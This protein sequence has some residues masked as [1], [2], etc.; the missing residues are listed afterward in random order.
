[1]VFDELFVYVFYRCLWYSFWIICSSRLLV[2][3]EWRQGLFSTDPRDARCF[4][5]SA[6]QT[7]LRW[8]DNILAIVVCTCRC[9]VGHGVFSWSS[10]RAQSWSLV[11]N[12][13]LVLVL[14]R[15][16][17]SLVQL[18]VLSLHFILGL[19]WVWYTSDGALCLLLR[20][21]RLLGQ[22]V[23]H[24]LMLTATVDT[25]LSFATATDIGRLPNKAASNYFLLLPEIASI[26]SSQLVRFTSC[27][28]WWGL[29]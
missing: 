13:V 14:S 2:W 3:A 5:C 26:K 8:L 17:Q 15:P 23:G 20:R 16:L 21:M 22:F 10:G 9:S 4:D 7:C 27:A 19:L 18:L 1:M 25:W 29:E 11:W 24:Y 6:K 12:T 28:C